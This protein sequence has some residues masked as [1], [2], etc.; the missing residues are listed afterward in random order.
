MKLTS[1]RFKD[2]VHLLDMISLGMIDESWLGRLPH[3]LKRR[4]Q[5]LIDNPG[6]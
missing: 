1:F 5:E 2:R 4:L 3:E 6:S